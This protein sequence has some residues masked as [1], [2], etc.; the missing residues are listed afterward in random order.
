MST[1]GPRMALGLVLG[2]AGCWT[3]GPAAAT[4]K[5]AVAGQLIRI[6]MPPEFLVDQR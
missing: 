2:L 4:T 5:L 6:G 1:L 3:V